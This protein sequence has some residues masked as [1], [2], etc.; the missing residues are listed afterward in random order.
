MCAIFSVNVVRIWLAG[1]TPRHMSQVK[2]TKKGNSSS[3]KS[4]FIWKRATIM[5]SPR[6]LV[7]ELIG[8][9]HVLWA[10]E[11]NAHLLRRGRKLFMNIVPSQKVM[12]RCLKFQA[13][14]R[15]AAAAIFQG[16]A[17]DTQR[18]FSPGRARIPWTK[19]HLLDF[20]LSSVLF[21]WVQRVFRQEGPISVY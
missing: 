14:G 18:L 16:K 17:A 12:L 19:D 4:I 21:E 10:G 7:R 1:L 2:S 9:E 13:I 8:F 15:E 11:A 20:R 5:M 3:K 6:Q